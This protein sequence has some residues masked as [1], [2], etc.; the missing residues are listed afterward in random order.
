MK[1]LLVSFFTVLLLLPAIINA[2]I[3]FGQNKKPPVDSTPPPPPPPPPPS[4]PS[5]QMFP[6]GKITFPDNGD[7]IVDVI[8]V[9][10]WVKNIPKG[11]YVWLLNCP[12]E[13]SVCWP[14][15][16]DVLYDNKTGLFEAYTNIGGDPN[17]KSDIKL[18]YVGYDSHVAFVQY[19]KEKDQSEGIIPPSDIKTI[20]SVTVIKKNL[21]T[22]E[23]KLP[24]YGVSTDGTFF[25]H[26][27]LIDKAKGNTPVLRS[28]LINWDNE[29]PMELN[30]DYYTVKV[31]IEKPLSRKIEYCFRVTERYF[32]P[33]L[34]I[35]N[36]SSLIN[37][38]DCKY[39]GDDGHN[40]YTTPL[41]LPLGVV[42]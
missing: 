18:V 21:S 7:S 28:A 35:D 39:N 16:R 26:R 37:D 14:Q 42:F 41:N 23:S 38:N 10:G 11:N 34:L 19:T 22:K 3:V 12:H 36:N 32:I 8:T 40:F 4:S 15:K 20:T 13:G 9:T 2:Q 24:L 17:L 29:I 1:R 6:S 31:T 30:G 27:S 5:S 25:I 33:Q